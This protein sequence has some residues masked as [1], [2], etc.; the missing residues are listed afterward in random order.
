M[1]S[2]SI[3]RITDEK[4][5]RKVW[6]FFLA[7]C[8]PKELTEKYSYSVTLAVSGSGYVDGRVTAKHKVYPDSGSGSRSLQLDWSTINNI[9]LTATEDHAVRIIAS[10]AAVFEP[11]SD[12]GLKGLHTAAQDFMNPTE[13]WMERA[14]IEVERKMLRQKVGTAV[15]THRK[16][17][18]L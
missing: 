3:D 10:L 12:L 13:G 15:N 5:A 6:R 16:E 11:V 1:T 18:A 17:V 2:N 7:E 14:R 8:V 9:A 4:M